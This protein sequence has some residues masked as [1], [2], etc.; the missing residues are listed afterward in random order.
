MFLMC[1]AFCRPSGRFFLFPAGIGGTRILRCV[2]YVGSVG[3]FKRCA[4]MSAL[5]EHGACSVPFLQMQGQMDWRYAM[6]G[7]LRFEA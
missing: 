4:A 2:D 7:F 6:A 3:R 5:K 1:Y